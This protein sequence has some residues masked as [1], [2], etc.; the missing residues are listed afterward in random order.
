MTGDN[1]GGFFYGAN[2][3]ESYVNRPDDYG[4]YIGNGKQRNASNTILTASYRLFKANSLSAYGELH[5]KNNVQLKQ[6]N[7]LLVIGVRSLLWNDYR[8]Y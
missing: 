1:T 5:F 3:Y 7:C 6:T 2:V 8:N 4:F